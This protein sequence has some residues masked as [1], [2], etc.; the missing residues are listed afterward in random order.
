MFCTKGVFHNV[1][2][3][4]IW[5]IDVMVNAKNGYGGYVG[6]DGWSVAM[7]PQEAGL[8]TWQAYIRPGGEAVTE[9]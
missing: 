3:D 1:S 4:E 8:V 5:M 9:Y 6:F 7:I 2:P